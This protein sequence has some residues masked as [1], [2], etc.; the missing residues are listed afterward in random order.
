MKT[1]STLIL[2]LGI[3]ISANAAEVELPTDL[4]MEYQLKWAGSTENEK[5]RA[6]RLEAFWNEYL[7]LEDGGTNKE[8]V[9]YEDGSHVGKIVWC[10]WQLTRAYIA[11]GQEEKA[12]DMMNWLAVNES[13]TRLA[14]I[15]QDRQ[16]GDLH[17]SKDE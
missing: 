17:E 6:D 3:A 14:P 5:E 11:S 7:P 4:T 12:L 2:C 9:G 1:L 13:R 15:E 10:A 16:Y 8:R